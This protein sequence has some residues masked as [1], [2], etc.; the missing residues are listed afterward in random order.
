KI[1]HFKKTRSFS[2]FKYIFAYWILT[3]FNAMNAK[4]TY[5][6]IGLMSGTS[7]DGLDM[8]YCEFKKQEA[9]SFKIK[10]AETFP[11][12]VSLAE[13]LSHSHLLSG[14]ELTLLDLKFGK[15]M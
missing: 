6:L 12:P 11:F 10:V 13:N 1:T 5:K 14:E 2:F 4:M 9:W 15:W 7:G 3:N 8:A